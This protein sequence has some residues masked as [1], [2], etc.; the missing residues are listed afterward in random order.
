MPGGDEVEEG[1][2]LPIGDYR[3]QGLA[4]HVCSMLWVQGLSETECHP[5]T[6]QMLLDP[7][8]T[9]PHCSQPLPGIAPRLWS[10]GLS[11]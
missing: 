10:Q 8:L 6:V 7:G 2:S 4:R 5:N 9:L 3:Q 11:W 1:L